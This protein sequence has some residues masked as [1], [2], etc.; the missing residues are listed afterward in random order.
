MDDHHGPSR[1][2]FVA[3]PMGF[4]TS[5]SVRTAGGV[6]AGFPRLAILITMCHN[7]VGRVA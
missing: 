2:L 5:H 1:L 3:K 7:W 4:A 6:A